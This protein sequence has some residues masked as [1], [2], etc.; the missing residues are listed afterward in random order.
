MVRGYDD[1]TFRPD[2]SVDRAAAVKMILGGLVTENEAADAAANGPL[3]TDMAA[4]AWYRGWVAKGI[5]R[6]FIDPPEKKPAFNG[7]KQ[8]NL[9]EALKMLEIAH[10]MDMSAYSEIRMPLAP[11][12]SDAT[13]WFYPYIRIGLASSIIMVEPDGNL[14]PEKTLTRGDVANLVYRLLMYKQN[15]RTQALLTMAETELSG[16]VLQN[17]S[18]EGIA[19]AKM[20]YARALLASRGALASRPDTALVKGAVKITEG[21]GALVA[22]YESGVS[23]RPADVITAAGEAWNSASAAIQFSPELSDIATSIQTIAKS[24]ADEARAM[25]GGQQ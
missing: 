9:A 7:G 5:A 8:V 25:Q 4:D 15:R 12:V 22:A 21:F 2:Q 10:G 17:L 11:D 1:G 20:A 19:Q 6:G 24:M 3:Y 14:R 16:N 18:P 13:A 23:G